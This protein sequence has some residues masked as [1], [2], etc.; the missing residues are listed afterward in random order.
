MADLQDV[1]GPGHAP[2]TLLEKHPMRDEDGIIRADFVQLVSDAVRRDDADLLSEIIADLHEADVGDLLEALEPDLRPRL[3][4]LAGTDFHFSALNEV[5]DTI[6]EEILEEL[7]PETVAEGVREL[8]SDDAVELLQ[9]LDQEDKEEILEHIPQQERVVLE[10]SLEYPEDSAGRRMQ[11]EFITVP[12]DWTVIQVIEHVR[13]T[14]DLPDRFYEVYVVDADHHWKGAVPL[15]VLLRARRPEPIADLIEEERHRVSV[16]DDQADVAR[17]FG[18]YN[19]IS[20]P[21]FDEADRLVGV[22]TI[23]DVVD[24]IEADADDEIKALGGVSSEE[25]LSDTVLTVTRGRFN[26]LLVNLATAFLASSVLGLFE[27]QLQKMV[28]L[29]VLAPIVAS[30]GGNAATQTMTVAVRALATRQLGAFNAVRIVMRE[31]MVGL[32]NGVAFAVITGIGAV[33]WFKEPGLGFVIGLAMICNLFAG[34]LGGILIPIGLDKIK[35][36]PAVASG[37]FVTTV[38]DVV[39]FFSFLGIASLWFGLK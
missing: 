22:I 9:N 12:P 21:V 13:D 37:A 14:A 19:L 2:D 5:D 20:A 8:E 38:T 15:D 18:K 29:A 39:G 23:D 1:A 11:T 36:D 28:A 32:L 3:I 27:D 4:E 7:E 6:R 26:W 10:R 35:A 33:A 24:V 30:Q 16:L 31:C 25:E 34:A 17:M